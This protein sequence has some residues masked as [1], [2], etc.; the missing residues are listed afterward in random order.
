MIKHQGD[1]SVVGTRH[2][3]TIRSCLS[4]DRWAAR[5]SQSPLWRA[6]KAAAD[7][8]DDSAGTGFPAV[9]L[10]IAKDLSRRGTPRWRAGGEIPRLRSR[11]DPFD[12]V[13][14]SPWQ[15]FDIALQAFTRRLPRHAH[16][17][18]MA[19]SSFAWSKRM[20]NW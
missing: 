13:L 15:D 7:A 20:V 9:I 3:S 17:H 16:P 6:G 1:V 10:R 18:T 5:R 4:P 14:H 2:G 12:V 19:Q 8:Q 11:D